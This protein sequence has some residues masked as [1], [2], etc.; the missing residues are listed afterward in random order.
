MPVPYAA[1][2]VE[3]GAGAGG[4]QA[5]VGE[6]PAAFGVWL[7]AACS[8]AHK[9]VTQLA[10]RCTPARARPLVHACPCMPPQNSQVTAGLEEILAATPGVLR[11]LYSVPHVS[12]LL[13]TTLVLVARFW[14]P[15]LLPL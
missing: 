1:G 11:M 2:A 5:Q 8:P 4:R 7:P 6:P 10:H 3:H 15:P 13:T 12:R 9:R 14:A